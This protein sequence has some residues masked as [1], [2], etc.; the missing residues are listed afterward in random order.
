MFREIRRKRQLLLKKE[1]DEILKY[2]TV[3]ILAV[4]GDN[5]YPYAVPMS[6]AYGEGKIYLHSARSGHKID[7]LKNDARVSF[8]VVDKDQIV[9]E[10]FTTYFR[11]VIIFGRA[12]IVKNEEERIKI[13]F[14]LGEK[15]APGRIAECQKEIQTQLNNTCVI[16]ITIEHMAGKEAIELVQSREQV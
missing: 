10:T 12:K 1:I 9:P 6:Y 4:H 7:S 16:E 14:R 13:L 15:Y 3:G 11:S 8:C 2:R 5:G